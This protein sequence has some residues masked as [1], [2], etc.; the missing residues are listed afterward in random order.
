MT[1]NPASDLLVIGGGLHGCA[2]ALFAAKAG[3]RVTLLEKDSVARHASGVNAG[4]VRRLWRDLAEVP[5]SERSMRM[6]HRISDITG[7]DCGFQPVPQVKVA[8]SEAD[9]AVLAARVA[10]MH[11]AGFSHERLIDRAEL[12]ALLPAVAAH[13]IGALVSEDGFAQPF[14]TTRVFARQARAAGVRIHEGQPV[15]RLRHEAGLWRAE[16]DEATWTAGRVL[17]CAGAWGGEIAARIGD[18][19]PLEPVAPL[20]LV[21]QRMRPFCTAVV[22]TAQRPLSFKQMPNGTVVIGGGR[23]GRADPARNRTDINFREMTQTARTAR[24]IFPIMAGA[25][26]QRS[27][28]GIEGRT[29]DR[30]PV[31]GR[32]ARHDT[33]FHAFGFSTHGFQLGPATG[34]LMAELIATGRMPPEIAPFTLTRFAIPDEARTQNRRVS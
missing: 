29:P 12:R 14:Q 28:S 34:A 3:L 17:N 18:D 24:E 16:T 26:I 21:T 15:R 7:E 1:T 23:L 31:I 22:G 19:V 27:W 33:A 10:R 11:A 2:A 13:C 6:W 4:G 5:L 30:L 9:M 32:S 8:E 25:V 20:M